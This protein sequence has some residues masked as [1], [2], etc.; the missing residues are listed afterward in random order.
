MPARS[1]FWPPAATAVSRARGVELEG[2]Q[3]LDGVDDEEDVAGTAELGE[4]RE[5]GDVA[6]RELHGGHGDDPR[7]GVGRFAD[8]VHG[9]AAPVRRQAPGFDA[10]PGEVHPRVGVRGVLDLAE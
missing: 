2:A 5:V 8:P 3:A 1:H 10:R 7:A 4:G 9:E 6:G